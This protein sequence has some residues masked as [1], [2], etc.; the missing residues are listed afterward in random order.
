M[1]NV[2]FNFLA[3][4]WMKRPENRAVELGEE[5]VDTADSEWD[6]NRWEMMLPAGIF[7]TKSETFLS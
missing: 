1:K 4:L 7:C 6:L 3:T 5:T 2:F